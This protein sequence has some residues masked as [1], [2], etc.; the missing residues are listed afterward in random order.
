M[1]RSNAWRLALILLLALAV[2]SMAAVAV[3]RHFAG[4]FALG[5]SDSYWVLAEAVA[6]G[7]PYRYGDARVFRTPGYPLL[8][9]PLFLL[10]NDPPVLAGRLHAAALGTIAVAGVFWLGRLVFDDRV[11][12]WAA[13]LAALEPSS[14]AASVLVLSEAPFAPLML[15]Q[16]ALGTAAWKARER[17]HRDEYSGLAR[18]ALIFAAAA[19]VAAGLA[20]LVRPSWLLF[21]PFAT[22]AGITLAAER[23]RQIVLAAVTLAALVLTMTPWWVRNALVSGHFIPTSLQVGASLYDGLRPG[24]D[25][26]S[27]MEFVSDFVEQALATRPE[28]ETPIEFERRLDRLMRDAALEWAYENPSEAS[29]LALRKFLRMWNIWPNEPAL[30]ALPI[31]LAVAITFIPLIVAAILGVWVVGGRQIP[32]LYLWL[33]SVYF[34]LLHMVF[35]SS[36]RYR[37]PAMLALLVLAAAVAVRW[38]DAGRPC[39]LSGVAAVRMPATRDRRRPDSK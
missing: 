3:D 13:L 20:T 14:V 18:R 34:S 11:G 32:Y 1:D 38:W 28:G 5:D 22:V 21:V 8:L 31:R 39:R 24:A 25:G 16:L 26:A 19:G 6:Q 9:A 36:I 37:Q 15:A 23:R 4:R 10:D 2:R 27:D 30:S 29:W 17:P 35:V 33:P 12:L 7:G